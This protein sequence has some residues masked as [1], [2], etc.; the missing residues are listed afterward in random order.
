[1]PRN[2]KKRIACEDGPAAD[3]ELIKRDPATNRTL[4][5]WPLA[6][7]EGGVK[8]M[9]V[10]QEGNTTIIKIVSAEGGGS[11]LDPGG[12]EKPQRKSRTRRAS[13]PKAAPV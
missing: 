1:M 6:V 4:D 10:K 12:W 2:R 8:K 7:V 3:I 13:E 9:T 11:W 5:R